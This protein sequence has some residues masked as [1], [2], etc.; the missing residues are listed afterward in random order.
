MKAH[1]R[2]DGAA[3]LG[4]PGAEP[5]LE[6]RDLSVSFDTPGATVLAN[7]A[8]P[9]DPSGYFVERDVRDADGSAPW[10]GDIYAD[11]I[12]G[13]RLNIADVQ[14]PPPAAPTAAELVAHLQKSHAGLFA[15]RARASSCSAAA[16]RVF[17]TRWARALFSLAR[18]VGAGVDV[19]VDV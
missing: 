8:L 10:T 17:L 18:G 4:F 2:C 13:F 11:G 12:G 15:L 19:D 9:T 6:V 5:L 7:N 3:G 16:G 1:P 14:A